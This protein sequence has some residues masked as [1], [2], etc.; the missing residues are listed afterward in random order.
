MTTGRN[1]EFNTPCGNFSYEHLAPH[2]YTHG[3]R[4]TELEFG[5]AYL[6]ASPEKALIDRI[7]KVKDLDTM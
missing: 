2:L 1:K 5:R 4:R 3:I 7:W 6:I